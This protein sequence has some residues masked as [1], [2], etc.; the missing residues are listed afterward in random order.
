MSDMEQQLEQWKPMIHYIIRH[1]SIHPNEQDD[2][3]QAA[4]L[5]LWRAITQ[6][7]MLNKTYCFLRIRGA[8]LNYQATRKKNLMFEL[9]SEQLPDVLREDDL[10]LV[11]WLEDQKRILLPRHYA[12]L[13]HLLAGTEETL[14]YSP[15]RLRAYK[16]E[17]KHQ[18]MSQD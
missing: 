18:L 12:L 5:A 14:P 8:V 9:C 16:A 3:A 2:C 15:S 6:H 17:L 10:S 4:R 7:K 11:L 13:C 1:L